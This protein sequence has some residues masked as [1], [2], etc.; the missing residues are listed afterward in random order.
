LLEF[1]D[2]LD[3]SSL[4]FVAFVLVAAVAAR[5]S[6]DDWRG[7]VVLGFNILFLANLL[8]GPV[9][10]AYALLSIA[11]W[12]AGVAI[13]SGRAG[14]RWIF[15]A[16]LLL[17]V[18]IFLVLRAPEVRDWIDAQLGGPD[19]LA[20]RIGVVYGY[21][22]FMFKAMNYLIAAYVGSA[23]RYSLLNF[24][25]F[26]FF[27]SS[28]TA[29]PIA[30]YVDLQDADFRN[31]AATREVFDGLQRILNGLIKKYV[32]VD[33][34]FQFSL[35]SFDSPAQIRSVAA[36]WAATWAHL[37]YIYVDFSAYTDIAIGIGLLFGYRLPEN[38]D[39]PLLKR[40]LVLFWESWHMSLTNWIREHIFTPLS[41]KAMQRGR[42][43]RT[44]VVA[45]G[46][47]VL[48]MAIFGLWHSLTLPFLVFGVVHGIA[49]WATQRAT[50][51]RRTHLSQHANHFVEQHWLSRVVGAL[52]VNVFVALSLILFRFDL[53][54]SFG[55]VRFL[56]TGLR[57]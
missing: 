40:N 9:L 7:A 48:T 41:W 43:G 17:L 27:F 39:Y 49:L 36:G 10:A 24:L 3:Y 22:Y 55:L 46:I 54:Q 20:A 25:N 31:R 33:L 2:P 11:L 32:L 5:A 38:F 50:L 4:S 44:G 57:P 21:S 30:R 37:L 42:L 29:G 15:H 53:E 8:S 1:I 56:F 47:Y 26:M 19:A 13:A 52:F 14:R 23:R 18:G 16:S 51:W 6:R 35:A 45:L 34:I 28:F 12:R